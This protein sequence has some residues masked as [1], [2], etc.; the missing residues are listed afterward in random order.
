MRDAL[1]HAGF[2]GIDLGADGTIYARL[3]AALPEFS[4]QPL[5]HDRWRFAI[6]WPLRADQA[7]R[8]AWA[9]RHP[10]APLDVDLGETR[11][12]FIGGTADLA[13]WAAVVNDMVAQCTLW[14]RQSRQ[15]DEGM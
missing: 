6:Q 14:R 8:A 4:V 15:R 9:A 13:H 10:D 11:M 12:Q 1:Q 3:D 7:Q 2:V 5:A